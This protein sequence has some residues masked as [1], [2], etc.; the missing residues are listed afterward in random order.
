MPK[1]QVNYGYSLY[2]AGSG[3]RVWS[4]KKEVEAKD[5]DDAINI[6]LSNA[7]RALTEQGLTEGFKLT[8]SISEVKEM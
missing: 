2:R 3:S 4:D 7:K 1:F 8:F 6:V 5:R